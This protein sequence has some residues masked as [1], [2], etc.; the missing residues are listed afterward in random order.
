MTDKG[1]SNQVIATILARRSVRFGYSASQIPEADLRAIVAAGVAAP[2]SKNARP[3]RLHVVRSRETLDAIATAAE[4]ADDVEDYVPPDPLTGEP[5]PVFQSTVRESAAVLRDAPS[6]IGLENRGVYIKDVNW[7]ASREPEVLARTLTA[8]GL[9][10]MGL[11]TALENMWLAANSLGV[12]AAFLGDLAI[13]S[14]AARDILGL[15]GDLVGLLALGYST[16]TPPARLEPAPET[17]SESAVL[18]H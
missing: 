13:A 10:A 17:Q 16:A 14:P 18:W 4:A 8:Y 5:S 3:W 11:G 9:E 6:A 1:A 12:Q 7:L 2:S 15:Q